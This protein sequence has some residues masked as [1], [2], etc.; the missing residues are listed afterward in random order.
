MTMY[1]LFRVSPVLKKLFG[2]AF[3]AFLIVERD[4]LLVQGSVR[5]DFLSIAVLAKFE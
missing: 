2:A 3:P 1:L 4:S 5:Q